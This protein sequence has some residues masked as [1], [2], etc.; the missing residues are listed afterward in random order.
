[1]QPE[2]KA[3]CGM[4][5]LRDENLTGFLASVRCCSACSSLWTACSTGRCGSSCWT[6]A[7]TPCAIGVSTVSTRVLST[8][9]ASPA[10]YQYTSHAFIEAGSAAAQNGT[11]GGVPATRVDWCK[12]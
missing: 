2:L 3:A 11:A 4:T 1:M 10:Q 8:M 5:A 9:N 6:A 12:H 7:W